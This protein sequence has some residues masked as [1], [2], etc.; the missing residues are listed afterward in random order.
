MKRFL[1]ITGILVSLILIGGVVVYAFTPREKLLAYVIPEINNIRITDIYINNQQATMKV[2]FNATSKIAP[3]YIYHL[4]Y[5]FRLYGQS[6][7]HGEQQLSPKSQTRRIQRFALPVSINYNQVG[8]LIQQQI[9]KNDSVEAHFQINCD[10]PFIGSRS[11]NVT[12]KLPIVLPV[13]SVPQIT[14]VKTE[15]FGFRH[16]RLI[17]TLTI[18]NP[19]NF[20][21]YL[22][23]LKLNAQL[24]DY[25]AAGSLGKDY[26]IQAHQAASLDIPSTTA[27]TQA[28]ADS[29]TS[30]SNLSGSYTLKA[31]LV[32]EPV[33]ESIGT[34]RFSVATNGTISAP[35]I[36]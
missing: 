27:I 9:T 29:L 25:L 6:I 23:D 36:K 1:K 21:F 15:D 12:R 30:A 11:F 13:L 35:E 3:V 22:R 19:N 10:L 33:S 4:T 28:Q 20:D 2:H 7:T 14:A 24:K 26:L 32:A 17:L 8:A 34:I 16:Q 5:D 31:N 18:Q